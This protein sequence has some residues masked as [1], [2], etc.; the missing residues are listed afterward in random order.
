MLYFIVY[1]SRTLLI[2]EPQCFTG[3]LLALH[4]IVRDVLAS[5]RDKISA[6]VSRAILN[7]KYASVSGS[8]E[9]GNAINL[10]S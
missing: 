6:K 5:H 8:Q 7:L 4:V 10:K 1:L 3:L 9:V 2:Y